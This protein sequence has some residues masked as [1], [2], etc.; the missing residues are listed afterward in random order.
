M[1]TLI[2]KVKSKYDSATEHMRAIEDAV[3]RQFS[4]PEEQRT[5]V[6]KALS[7]AFDVGHGT[8][9]SDDWCNAL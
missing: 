4:I 6:R 8:N 2:D 3:M 1:S 7:L 5:Q 9:T